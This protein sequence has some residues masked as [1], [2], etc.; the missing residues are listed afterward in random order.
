MELQPDH[1][2]T[3]SSDHDAAAGQYWHF[4]VGYLALTL[5]GS[6]G[7]FVLASGSSILMAGLEIVVAL[8]VL[9]IASLAALP[10]LYKDA[11]AI[12]AV[13]TDWN[14]AWWKYVGFVAVVTGVAFLIVTYVTAWKVA[15]F[16]A[17]VGLVVATVEAVVVYL[18]FRAKHVGLEE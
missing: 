10:M 7:I 5:L 17:A 1:G 8:T 9:T 13:K 16:V 14:P 4:L 3:L 12:A 2:P 6:V 11:Q 18:Y 15:A